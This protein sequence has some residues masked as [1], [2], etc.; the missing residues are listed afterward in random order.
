M[1][2]FKP[3]SRL[4]YQ[5]IVSYLLILM[6]PVLVIGFVAY[7]YFLQLMK[8]EIIRSNLTV[9]NQVKD[10]IDT[11]LSELG[12]IA[13]HISAN[14]H[15]SPYTA[16][17]NAFNEMNAISE[18]RNYASANSFVSDILLY[19]RGGDKL[20]SP[21][22]VFAAK[23]YPDK[24]FRY[25]KWSSADFYRDIN[26]LDMTLLRTAENAFVP[27][28]EKF[29]TYIVPI[30]YR[31]TSPYGT[32]LFQMKA[33]TINEMIV[34]TFGDE[35]GNA[36]ILNERNE[37]ITSL[38]PVSADSLGNWIETI[39]TKGGSG[40]G[41]I[42]FEGSDYLAGYVKS[43]ASGWTYLSLVNK[44]TAMKSVQLI[45]T[46]AMYSLLLLLLLGGAAIMY[47]MT[48]NYAPIRKLK[49][50][51]ESQLNRAFRNTNELE[52]IRSA[53][54]YISDNNE[55][56]HRKLDSSKPALKSYLL[57]GLLKGEFHDIRTFNEKGESADVRFGNKL[58][59]VVI[60]AFSRKDKI[61]NNITETLVGEIE[62]LLNEGEAESGANLEAQRASFEGYGLDSLEGNKLIFII[63]VDSRE[64][65]TLTAALS[66]I[67]R[68]LVRT[69][70]LHVTIGVGNP[71]AEAGE[72]GKSYIEATGAVDYRLIK[73][74]GELILFKE[75]AGASAAQSG[76]SIGDWNRLRL[77]M[78]QGDT[79]EVE[80]QLD[81]IIASIT[82]N[83]VPLFMA[84]CICFDL[85]RVIVSIHYEM[86][87]QPSDRQKMYPDV[88]SL[89]EFETVEELVGLV[90][91]I[92][93]DLC[94]ILRE[95]KESANY[96]LRDQIV[97]YIGRHYASYHFSVQ[98][99]AD[100]L[101]MSASY[102]SRYFKDQTGQTIL[103]YV[104]SVR[105]EKAK[106][107][108]LEGT[109]NMQQL[110]G[111]IGFGSVPGFIRKFKEIEG[112][113]PGEFRTHHKKPSM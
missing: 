86:N 111:Q 94:G 25:E 14:P 74:H 55:E 1:R 77:L 42:G 20:Y 97:D 7:S 28:P 90:R 70:G 15:L 71:Y 73:G 21:Y 47:V 68:F 41:T 87:V 59:R 39:R 100:D 11:K 79:G 46:R 96:R 81:A 85:I 3:T 78:I 43:E 19:Y 27:N 84:R 23:T 102:L 104:T 92:S 37:V 107:L 113:T 10:T 2:K 91:T 53:F 44:S 98:T 52:S 33:K 72:I 76:Y 50:F 66:S 12:N 101:H 6:L 18:L 88:M 89:T 22:S 5:Y 109:D 60:F 99:M 108:L 62:K 64:D 110:A 57:S 8:E 63:G 40:S 38:A 24:I 49:F 31:E 69:R 16:T 106:R 45:Q 36:I 56:L 75:V 93:A 105:M 34:T 9:L 51:V 30:P 83:V 61:P 13:V 112:M 29:I 80:A 95:Q 4:F 65:V 82:E 17:K 48:L 103:Q 58:F 67:Q 54:R 32:V 26:G 35:G